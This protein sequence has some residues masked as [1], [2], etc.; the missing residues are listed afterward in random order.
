MKLQRSAS[1]VQFGF[2]PKQTVDLD[3]RIWKVRE[4]VNPIPVPVDSTVLRR[5]LIRACAPWTLASKDGGLGASLHANRDIRLLRVD[6]DAGVRVEPFPQT[7][8]CRSCHRVHGRAGGCKCGSRQ[9]GQ[10]PFVGYC[11]ECGALREPWIPPCPEHNAIRVHLPGTASAAEIVFDCPDCGKVLRKGFGSPK[12]QCGK[13]NLVFN[14]HRSA[15]VY[16]ARTVV[17]VNPPSPEVVKRLTQAG[18]RTRAL[19]WL[20]GGMKERRAEDLGLTRQ[21]LVATLVSQGLSTEA[22]GRAADAAGVDLAQSSPIELDEQFM[23]PA[24]DDAETVAL[25]FADS[26][27]C[28]SDLPAAVGAKPEL[29]SIFSREY[30]AAIRR[31]GF[32][33][34]ELVDKFPVLTATFG[35]TRGS[36]VPGH[37]RLVTFEGRRG[38]VELYG[39]VSPTEALFFRLDP[40]RTAQWIESHGHRL[41]TWNDARSARLAILGGLRVPS[42]AGSSVT[43]D[44]GTLL[45]TLVHSLA[46]RLIRQLAVVAGID[47]NSLSELLVPLHLG[48]FIYAANRGDFVLGGLQAVFET[49]LHRV[50]HEF[51]NAEQRCALDPGCSLA[52]AACMACLHIGEPS[53]RYFNTHLDRRLLSGRTGWFADAAESFGHYS[54]Q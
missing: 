31:A 20:L 32:D 41:A 3:R 33:S 11:S 9:L 16:T 29:R 35:F 26:R 42:S 10:L 2:L 43:G 13:G 14:V 51:V 46:H 12:C 22:A 54:S 24:L 1:Q 6:N 48:F 25:A 4:W 8:M 19:S 36:T 37:S 38:E 21:A 18:G 7:W 52:G 53:C 5:E 40:Q 17:V 27:I 23:E 47:R 49:E 50:L 39:D 34:V 30:P 28:I 15:A 45:L 44:P